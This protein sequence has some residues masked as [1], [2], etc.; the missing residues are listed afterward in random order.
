MPEGAPWPL[1]A[2]RSL[3]STTAFWRR[4]PSTWP[5]RWLI[6][7]RVNSLAAALR[8]GL[9]SYVLLYDSLLKP[10]HHPEIV[11]GGVAVTISRPVG[12]PPAIG[13][14]SGWL[15]G[16]SSLVMLSD[17]EPILWALALCFAETYRSWHS[18]VAGDQR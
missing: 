5:R 16:F 14:W 4:R 2:L 9:C 12:A 15:S 17:T 3:S 8:L 6:D 1:P 7:R 13:M 18:D 10:R 11:I